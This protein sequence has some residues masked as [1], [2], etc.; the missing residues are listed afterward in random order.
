MTDGLKRASNSDIAELLGVAETRGAEFG[1]IADRYGL[2]L[3]S[4]E[5]E[6]VRMAV[7]EFHRVFAEVLSRAGA[8][9]IYSVSEGLEMIARFFRVA[10]DQAQ[11]AELMEGIG[12]IAATHSR[13]SGLTQRG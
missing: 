9:Q 6:V 4:G 5:P 3:T 11:F 10:R 12:A 7:A 2:A 8:D 13:R 1:A